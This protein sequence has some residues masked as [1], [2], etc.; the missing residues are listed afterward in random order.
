MRRRRLAGRHDGVASTRRVR[1]AGGGFAAPQLVDG[2]QIAQALERVYL[3]IRL[4]VEHG[5]TL[6]E[7]GYRPRKGTR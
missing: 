5:D 2:G 6:Y 7:Q 4:F 1:P 3:L